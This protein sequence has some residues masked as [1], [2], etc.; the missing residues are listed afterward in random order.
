LDGFNGMMMTMGFVTYKTQESYRVIK[1]YVKPGMKATAV[2][3]TMG[4]V[5]SGFNIVR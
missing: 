5:F 2:N 4:F 3:N 1:S